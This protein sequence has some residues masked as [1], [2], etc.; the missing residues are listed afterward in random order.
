MRKA[1]GL[2]L[3]IPKKKERKENLH[4]GSARKGGHQK[5]QEELRGLFLSS[6]HLPGF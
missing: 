1:L 6:C 5:V 3:S 4:L 2:T